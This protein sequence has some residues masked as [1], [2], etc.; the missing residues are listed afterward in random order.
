MM[1][2]FYFGFFLTGMFFMFACTKDTPKPTCTDGSQNG[3]ETDIDCG[4]SDCSSCDDGKS[5]LEPD[6][7]QSGVCHE[8]ICRAPACG[9][10]RIQAPEECDDE[11]ESATCN[12]DCTLSFCGDGI[13]NEA[14]GEECDDEGESATCNVDCT[15]SFCGDGIVNEAAGE[16]CDDGDENAVPGCDNCLFVCEYLIDLDE[17]GTPDF[18]ETVLINASFDADIENWLFVSVVN[19]IADG[20]FCGGA[21]EISSNLPRAFGGE[22]YVFQCVAIDDDTINHHLAFAYFIA[23]GQEALDGIYARI[24]Y[25]STS[26][27]AGG[28][29]LSFLDYPTDGNWNTTD[30]WQ[31]VNIEGLDPVPGSMAIGLEL[32]VRDTDTENAVP[33]VVALLD[34]I[35]LRSE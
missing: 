9:D 13:V 17:N 29:R 10:G 34:Q 1:K 15:L 27:C 26:D 31:V 32:G 3:S 30:S 2:H 19:W 21:A 4:G 23:S 35:L 8:F 22:G 12:V 28:T 16:E 5:C 33:P 24:S 18:S 14:A 7:C 25:Y 6:D 20:G 11:G